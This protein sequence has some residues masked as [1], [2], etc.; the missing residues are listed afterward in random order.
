M[1]NHLPM[2][3]KSD[4]KPGRRRRALFIEDLRPSVTAAEELLHEYGYEFRFAKTA[5]QGLQMLAEY[6]PQL[7][8][9]DSII[10]DRL[11]DL[12]GFSASLVDML[13]EMQ[14]PN[15]VFNGATLYLANREFFQ[16]GGRNILFLTALSEEEL[17]AHEY[18]GEHIPREM[19]LSKN[20]LQFVQ[21]FEDFLRSLD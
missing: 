4:E 11:E 7:V 18:K 20:D 15:V 9:I 5:P 16:K 13:A 14:S 8:L 17:A 1:T 6:D 3:L 19:I 10:N 12:A 2:P 21:R